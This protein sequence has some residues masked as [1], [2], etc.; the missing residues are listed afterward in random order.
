[1]F[2]VATQ[3]VLAGLDAGSSYGPDRW[4][5]GPGWWLVFPILFWVLVLTAVGYAIFRRTPARSARA[6]AERLLAE[7]YA[8]GEIGAD[9]L[10]ERRNVLRNK[11]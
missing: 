11:G 8:R 10:R 3:A 7:R 4:D 5:G 6:T 1:M 9:E 2:E